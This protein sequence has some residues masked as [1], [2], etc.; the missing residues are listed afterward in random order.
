ML[1]LARVVIQQQR[2]PQIFRFAAWF[3][4][5]ENLR[6]VLLGCF[7]LVLSFAEAKETNKH[8]KV[9]KLDSSKKV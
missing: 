7:S 2:E 8:G 3:C 5:K 6:L 4:V 9:T 1:A